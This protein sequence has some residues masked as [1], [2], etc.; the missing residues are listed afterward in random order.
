VKTSVSK[1]ILIIDDSE[2]VR[3]QIACELQ[4]AALCD[5]ILHAGDGIE[6][7]K[8]LLGTSVD[9]ILCDLEMPRIDGFKLLGMIAGNE[10]LRDIPV[11][12][13][14][15]H[16][17]RSLKVKLLG[18]GASDYVTKPFDAGELIARVEVHLKIKGLQDELK[19]S[20]DRLLLLSNTDP[21]TLIFNRR[22]MMDM[23][24]KEI[25]R[26]IRTG[27]QLSLLMVDIDHFKKINDTYG[28]QNGDLVLVAVADALRSSLRT[29]DFAARY[30]GEEFVLSLPETPH[31]GA[32]LVAERLRESVQSLP[33]S[34]A[35]SGLKIT[36]S[37]GVATFPAAAIT[38]IADLIREADEAMYRAKAAGRNR[39]FSMS[40]K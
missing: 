32:M 21:L 25:Q 9:L 29:Y 3:L 24:E 13:L 35:L 28:H 40:R 30:G 37:M 8:L 17:D 22:Y 36:V 34:G 14:T 33:Y 26:A 38:S 4:G 11:I 15:G 31:E 10:Q 16:G 12:M 27:S 5:R 1:S 18:H 39:I 7:F 6:A 2:V 19:K 20:N 23:L